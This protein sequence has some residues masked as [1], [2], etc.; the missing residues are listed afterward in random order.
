VSLKIYK[1]C[2]NYTATYSRRV[3]ITEN[4]EKVR[5]R[6][7]RRRRKKKKMIIK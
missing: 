7:R 4:I 5:R 2:G 3:H 6:R 1:G